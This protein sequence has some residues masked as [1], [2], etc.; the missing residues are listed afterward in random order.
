MAREFPLVL[1]FF[2]EIS[3]DH[4]DD[5]G[6]QRVLNWSRYEPALSAT[7]HRLVAISSESIEAQ[8]SWMHLGPEWIILSDVELRLARALPLPTS[9]QGARRVYRPATL[10]VRHQRMAR[11]FHSVDGSDA[12][13]VTRWV[14]KHAR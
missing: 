2:G 4:V 7:G 9:P 8:S 5:P 14:E 13:V 11:S 10:V 12:R 3:V 6:V 1:C